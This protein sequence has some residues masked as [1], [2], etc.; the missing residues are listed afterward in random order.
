MDK[1]FLEYSKL[2]LAKVSFDKNLFQKEYRKA[3]RLLQETEKMQLNNWIKACG[4]Y[5]N[6]SE[7][8]T[9]KHHVPE[10]HY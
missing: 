7:E 6:L 1:S 5:S 3:V 2:I 10:Y 8:E 9:W 4:L